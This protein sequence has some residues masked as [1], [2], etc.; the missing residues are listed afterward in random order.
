[1]DNVI[2]VSFNAAK[3]TLHPACRVSY[4]LDYDQPV[5]CTIVGDQPFFYFEDEIFDEDD[6][7]DDI[8]LSAMDA[9][10]ERL[11]ECIDVYEDT[12]RKIA[13]YQSDH[14]VTEKFNENCGVFESC[15]IQSVIDI[16]RTSRSG[17]AY[18][19]AIEDHNINIIADSGQKESLYHATA[20]TIYLGTQQTKA[21]AVIAL[22]GS[23]RQ[24]WH[25][26]SGVH[27]NPVDYGPDDAITMNRLLLAD[28]QTAMVRMAWELQL[29]GYQNAWTA[30]NIGSTGDMAR[31]MAREAHSDFRSLFN[32]RA[33][34]AVFETWFLSERSRMADDKIIRTM[35]GRPKD[36]EG[37]TSHTIHMD[38]FIRD[39]GSMPFG[40]NYLTPHIEII[41]QDGIFSEVRDR[42]N[43]NFLWFIKF[44]QSFHETEQYLRTDHT[45]P[46]ASSASPHRISDNTTDGSETGN[47]IIHFRPDDIPR[48]KSV[49]S[50]PFSETGQSADIIDF[51]AEL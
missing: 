11:K 51:S 13:T 49:A 50:R 35:L 2:E 21:E 19:Q 4:I 31:A 46:D 22:A 1:M 32:G 30:L 16:I 37:V 39:L 33:N 28:T 45:F 10:L 20:K 18:L 24:A 36:D 26:I 29:A 17:R 23:L 6:Y 5:M 15:D 38:A 27:I 48:E 25:D 34:T 41:L 40:E 7:A 8:D 14:P 9:E 3:S 42:S 43:A 44:E 12:N 47:T